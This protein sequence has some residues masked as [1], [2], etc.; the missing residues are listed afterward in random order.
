MS[1]GREKDQKDY[2][3]EELVKVI[4]TALTS[5]N[6]AVQNALR[7][8]LLISTIVSAEHPDQVMKNGPLARLFEDM[9]HLA[10]RLSN[11][12]DELNQMK[13]ALQKTQVEP[14]MPTTPATSP[15]T[16]TNPNR[17]TPTWTS[18]FQAGDD[19]NYKGARSTND[20]AEWNDL[21]K[22]LV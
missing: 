16:G 4:D 11:V 5:D 9:N 19:P 15:W 3:L 10:R 20:F 14:F 7:S 18:S 17:P 8:L 2:D 22:K 1:T 13:W 6:A 21:A 12:E